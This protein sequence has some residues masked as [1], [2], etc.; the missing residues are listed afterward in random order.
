MLMD[1]QFSLD[2]KKVLISGAAGAIGRSAARACAKM[3]AELVLL[4]INAVDDVRD[5]L[6]KDG[7]TVS[8]QV[9]DLTNRK[10]VEGCI[11]ANWPIDA[12]IDCAGYYPTG[13]W[14]DDPEWDVAFRKVIDI[15]LYGPLNLARAVLPRMIER[16]GG[17]IVLIGSLAGRTGGAGPSTQAHYVAAKGGVHALVRWLSRRGIRSNVLVNG[18]AP[19]P[20]DTPMNSGVVLNPDAH[21]SGRMGTPDEI[22][23]PA[24][25]LCGAA[26][27]FMSGVVLDINGGHHF[28]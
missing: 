10:Q 15:N 14:I 24:A 27:G 6:R 2:G 16:R 22:G 3:G 20:I 25:F 4:D 17:R 18:I 19:G 26:S 12:V 11:D 13:D 9:V 5:E 7:T 28:S 1:N 23:W 8:S 21:P